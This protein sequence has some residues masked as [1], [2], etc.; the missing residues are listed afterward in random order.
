MLAYLMSVEHFKIN[1]GFCYILEVCSLFM[2]SLDLKQRDKNTLCYCLASRVSPDKG[3]LKLYYE[4]QREKLLIKAV[5][6]A[7]RL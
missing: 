7:N 6:M 2:T 1:L 5:S 3:C 4:N